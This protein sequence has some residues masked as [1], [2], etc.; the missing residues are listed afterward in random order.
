MHYTGPIRQD[1]LRIIINE[2]FSMNREK[3]HQP[4][5]HLHDAH[6]PHPPE[7]GVSRSRRK[8]ILLVPRAANGS[9]C[10]LRPSASAPPLP[11]PIV[12]KVIIIV[13][14]ITCYH[15]MIIVIIIIITINF[16]SV[17]I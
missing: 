11:R 10:C 5:H 12:V 13:I 9:Y 1:G 17:N 14:I 8:T 16:I 4:F 3:T 6:P 7:I 15:I 2:N